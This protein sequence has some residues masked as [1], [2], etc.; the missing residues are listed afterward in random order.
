MEPL[1]T[2]IA[3]IAPAAVEA[4]APKIIEICSDKFRDW[5][6][7]IKIKFGESFKTSVR[8]AYEKHMFFSSVV[9]P[10]RQLKL[11]NYYLPLTL[12]SHNSKGDV[13]S[14]TLINRYPSHL[15][16]KKKDIL[17][18]DSA[19]MG[20]STILKFIFLQA[21]ESGA[22]IPVFLELRKL[23]GGE[24][25]IFRAI[26]DQLRFDFDEIQEGL[27][28]K[29]IETG[30]FIFFLDGYDEISEDVRAEVTSSIIEFKQRANKNKFIISSRDMPGVNAFTDFFRYNIQPLSHDEAYLLIEKYGENEAISKGLIEK[31]KDEASEPIREF[32]K[33]PLLVSL[34]YKAYEYKK[35]VPLRKHVFYRQVFEALFENH[36]LSKESGELNRKKKTGLDI[37]LFE[38]VMRVVGV[39]TF[40]QS[41]IEYSKDQLLILLESC[42]GLVHPIEFN[43][44]FL[45]EDLTIA[46]PLFTLDGVNIRWQ[47]KSLQEYFA[48]LYV[49][50]R[51]IDFHKQTLTGMFNNIKAASY[52]N[53]FSLFIDI[54]PRSGRNILTLLLVN[55]LLRIYEEQPIYDGIPEIL[56][57]HRRSLNSSMMHVIINSEEDVKAWKHPDKVTP[58][59]M[60]KASAKLNAFENFKSS[61]G[62]YVSNFPGCFS[63]I[64]AR[65]VF[66][67]TMAKFCLGND[68]NKYTLKLPNC[69]VSTN[70]FLGLP[71]Y[72]IVD[73]RPE[74]PANEMKY[75]A[76]VNQAIYNNA[77]GDNAG[78][79]LDFEKLKALKEE[80]ISEIRDFSIL[81]DDIIF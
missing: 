50:S 6:Q 80:I 77:T 67:S 22:G 57:R 49:S 19:G 25:A 56:A 43:P 10:N 23:D 28:S 61:R 5:S 38:L 70:A 4:I 55:E 63:S 16:D 40:Q 45:L 46:V 51:G 54:D 47:H 21:I 9:F 73:S 7:D 79:F 39:K 2:G 58:I 8:Q 17:V 44:Q 60:E 66:L 12:E 74:N 42:K 30:N 15:M 35:N 27:L 68:F 24:N 65:G 32:L 20:K 62:Y 78:Y 36:D 71:P 29:L 76:S 26:L 11:Y 18:V 69:E 3:A 53:F 59:A 52:L 31:L 75:F 48:A 72:F 81:S 33:N 13:E 64:S 1:F 41:K 14:N 34:L 37:H